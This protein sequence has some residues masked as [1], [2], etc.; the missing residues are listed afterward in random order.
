LEH[1]AVVATLGFN[2]SPAQAV[3]CRIDLNLAGIAR[4]P[5]HLDSQI[6]VAR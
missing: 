6:D 4:D 5:K 1:V 2:F 3:S